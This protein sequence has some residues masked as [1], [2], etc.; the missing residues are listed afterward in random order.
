MP[1]KM[2]RGDT[3][4]AGRFFRNLKQ[5]HV[6]KRYR[7]DNDEEPRYGYR[8]THKHSR[9][10]QNQPGGFSVNQ[11][12][13]IRTP[14]CSI[15][16]QPGSEECHHVACIDLDALNA[17]AALTTR[18]LAQYQPIVEHQNR[19][20]FELIPE[21]GTATKWLELYEV[22]EGPPTQEKLPST[23]EAEEEA[24]LV[25]QRFAGIFSIHRWVRPRHG[26]P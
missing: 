23:T 20:H 5:K 1:P 12:A 13:C 8:L 3:T 10:A 14:E 22:M 4:A 6:S 26:G 21:D 9:D 19:C 16:I 7:G 11:V 18:F 15:A 25:A 24:R 2:R 17:S